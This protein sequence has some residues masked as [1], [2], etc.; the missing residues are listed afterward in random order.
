MKKLFVFFW[1]ILVLVFATQSL[2]APS[3]ITFLTPETDPSSIKVDSEIIAAFEKTHPGVKV[4][5]T[6]ANLNDVLPKLSAMLR[7]GTAPDLAFSS[8]KYV[9]PLVDQGYLVPM[10]DVFKKLGDIPRKFVTTNSKNKIYDIPAAMESRVLYYRKDLFAAAGIKPPKTFD[11]WVNAAKVLTKDTNGDGKIDQYGISLTG[12]PPEV[13]YDFSCILWANGADLIDAKLK[14]AIDS[15]EAIQ[16][17]E[18]LG[19]LK[20]YCPPGVANTTFKDVSINFANGLVAMA[21]YPGRMMMNIDRYNPGLA[22]KVGIVPIPY[23]PGNKGKNPVSHATINNFVVFK[24][25]K[26][27]KAAKEFVTFYMQDK[28]YLKFLVGATPGHSLPVRNSWLNNADYF[29]HPAIVK[30]KALVK[31]SMDYAFKYGTDFLF[32]HPGVVDPYVGRA[33]ADPTLSRE[34]NKFFVE[35]TTAKQ[36]LTDTGKAWRDMLGIK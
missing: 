7:A 26:N 17:L 4:E 6:H 32:R 14:V 30:W 28:Q 25:S 1:A 24:T 10:D 12:A 29:A 20:E 9:T 34:V 31:E 19:K 11:E 13:G 16:A 33:S 27:V 36:A 23:G 35:E 3:V 5:L 22:P 8:P 15:P 2:A 21:V 18:Y